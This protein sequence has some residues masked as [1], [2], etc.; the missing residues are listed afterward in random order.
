MTGPFATIGRLGLS[1]FQE[2]G[3]PVILA[4]KTLFWV[5][6]APFRKRPAGFFNSPD[7]FRQAEAVG[8]K[9]I[10]IVLLVSSLIGTILVL[11]TAYQLEKF[12]QVRLVAQGVAVTLVRE[13]GPL[14]TA[15]VLI[16]RVGSA[17]TAELGNMKINEEVL[18]LDTMAINPVGWLVV[19]RALA[20]AVMQPCLSIFSC[21]TGIFGGFLMGVGVFGIPPNVYIDQTIR[22][23]VLQDIVSGLLK[24]L[25][26][27]VIISM[28]C[29]Y[30]GLAVQGGAEQVGEAT[31][32]SV[33]ASLVLV[34]AA[35][36]VF[37][38]VINVF[39]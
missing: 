26:F 31:R 11:Q 13:L 1:F 18:A 5:T 7:T 27:A 6:I 22:G 14:M 39:F 20:L 3:G 25:T 33:V 24:S 38:A 23:L 37:T 10:P 16:G 12:G 34:I 28:I 30:K 2:L 15:I 9:S 35:D 8:V 36:A 32:N 17:F 19:P 29:C 4:R 21:L